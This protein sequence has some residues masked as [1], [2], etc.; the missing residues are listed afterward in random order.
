M[1]T[2][3]NIGFDSIIVSHRLHHSYDSF[4]RPQSILTTSQLSSPTP[5]ISHLAP[6][7]SHLSCACAPKKIKV[8]ICPGSAP[9]TPQTPLHPPSPS[10]ESTVSPFSSLSLTLPYRR[11]THTPTI[12]THFHSTLLLS[13]KAPSTDIVRHLRTSQAEPNRLHTILTVFSTA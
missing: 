13:R 3:Q 12:P 6:R 2:S 1:R 9:S 11:A 8:L 4:E 7:T 5:L 10:D